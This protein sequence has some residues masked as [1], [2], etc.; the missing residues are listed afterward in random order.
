MSRIEMPTKTTTGS[1][2][3]PERLQAERTALLLACAAGLDGR[4]EGRE[5]DPPYSFGSL[6]R[7]RWLPPGMGGCL[8]HRASWC[9]LV[10]YVLRCR[11]QA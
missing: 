2:L 5:R 4:E 10:Q 6:G 1:E 9:V 3:A 7:A 8:A 11:V